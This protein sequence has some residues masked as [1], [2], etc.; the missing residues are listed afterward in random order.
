MNVSISSAILQARVIKE[1]GSPVLVE[2]RDMI[3]LVYGS[4]PGNYAPMLGVS[5]HRS[6]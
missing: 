6:R 3:C 1:I 5:L 4:Q 2:R